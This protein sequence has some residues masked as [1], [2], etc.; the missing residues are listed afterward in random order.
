M[1]YLEKR[2]NEMANESQIE[3]LYAKITDEP[4]NVLP[5][6]SVNIRSKLAP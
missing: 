4:F 5:F 6:Q 1:K 3:P 2:L